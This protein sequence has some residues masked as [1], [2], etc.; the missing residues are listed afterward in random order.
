MKILV[1]SQYFWP[2]PFRINDVVSELVERGHEVTVLTGWPN[3]P[4]GELYPAFVANQGAF[5]RF[6]GA[7]V[8]RVPLLPRRKGAI[9]L[10]I[11]YLS[12]VL[13]GTILAPWMLRNRS[14]D[15]IFIC[16]LSPVTS[17]LPAL[18]YSALRRVPTVMWVLDLWPET[19]EALGVVRSRR[20]LGA[21]SMLV[22]WIYNRCHLVLA[23]SM[24]FS[25]SIKSRLRDKS[26]FGYLPS[27][28][29]DVFQQ[30]DAAVAPELL[31]F[32]DGVFNV[33]FA[34]NIGESQDF[35]TIL[36]AAE[37]LASSDDVRLIIVGE[38]RVAEWLRLEVV[39]RKLD[40]RVI[41]LG[42]YPIE[43]M[44]AFFV[45]A[46]AFLVALRANST[47]EGTIPGKV[48]AYLSS[49]KPIIGMLG[50]EGARVIRD[51]E[52]G[53]TCE[54]GDATSLAAGISYLASLDAAK[55][56]AMGERGRQYAFVHFNRKVLMSRL[57]DCL[58]EAAASRD[59]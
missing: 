4:E 42:R 23:Q 16:Q 52:A 39:R 17:A 5:G 10:T 13:S 44:P 35:P 7:D 38:G 57:C 18:A 43:R 33:L 25:E 45:G 19:L 59:T 37:R 49:G 1:V 27:W 8:I 30:P 31:V 36:D 47:F 2:E 48:Q 53:V 46:D 55:R 50:G 21:V 56:H 51:A 41:L 20:V 58:R 11:N 32:Q 3:Y 22:R 15:V 34:G 6:A 40:R 54:P 29:E 14:F 26:R 28:A 9:A 24:A 12:F